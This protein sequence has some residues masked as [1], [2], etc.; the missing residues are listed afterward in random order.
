MNHRITGLLIVLLVLLNIGGVISLGLTLG[1]GD[2][3]GLSSLA[4]LLGLDGLGFW[5]LRQLREQ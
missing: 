4:W 1:R 5:L 3:S 2:L